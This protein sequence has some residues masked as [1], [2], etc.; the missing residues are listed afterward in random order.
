MKPYTYLIGWPEHNTWYYGVRYAKGCNPSDLWNPYKTSSI[1]VSAFVAKHGEPS[2]RQIRHTFDSTRAARLWEERV[3]KRMKVVN[4][5]RWLNKTDNKSIAPLYGN[6]HPHYGKIG[7]AH[8]CYGV[9]RPEVSK[10]K[11]IEWTNNNPMRNPEVVARKIAKTSGANHHMKRPE[12]AEKVSGHNNWIHKDPIALEKRRQEFVK[13]NKARQG[14]H[15]KRLL[16]RH[17]SK[18]YSLVQIKQHEQRCSANLT[19]SVG[20][21]DKAVLK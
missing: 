6:D 15:Y 8:H 18:D 20:N 12:V 2:I 13:R 5:A 10:S 21:T 14:T 11:R 1:H 19:S 7:P 17:C 3:L 9:K 4:D 16:C